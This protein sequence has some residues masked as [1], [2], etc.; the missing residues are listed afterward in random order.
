MRLERAYRSEGSAAIFTLAYDT[1]AKA[2]AAHANIVGVCALVTATTLRAV[3]NVMLCALAIDA[4][5]PDS[6]SATSLHLAHSSLCIYV[7]RVCLHMSIPRC[8]CVC[9]CVCV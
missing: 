8:V 4:R 3:A 7:M 6:A 1:Q 2:R 5:Q 9:E